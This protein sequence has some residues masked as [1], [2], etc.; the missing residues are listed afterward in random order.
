MF[1]LSIALCLATGSAL[2]EMPRFQK[3]PAS[4][5]GLRF[6][7]ANS[8]TAEKRMIETMPGGIAAFDFDNDGLIDIFFANGAGLKKSANRLFKNEGGLKFRDVTATAGLSGEGYAIGAVAGDF[9]N[10]G[11]TDLFVAGDR[12]NLLY[13]NSGHGKFEDITAKS[14]I[15]SDEWSIAGG[16]FDYDADGL[17]DLFIANYG[18]DTQETRYCGDAAKKLRIYCH[19]KYFAPR[20]NQLYRNLGGGKFEDVTMKSGIGAHKG[21]GMSIA[22]ADYDADGWIDIFVTNDNLANFLFRNLGNG[23]FEE[24]A[25]LA[26]VALLDHGKPIA[27]MGADFRDADNDGRPDITVTALSGETFPFFRN[28][29]GGMF[30]DATFASKIGPLS[31]QRAGWANAWIDFNND[32]WKDLFSANAHVNDLVEQFEPGVTYKQANS[33]FVN[34]NG[35]T[36]VDSQCPALAAAKAAHRGAAFADFDNDGRIDVVVSVLGEPAELWR[37][38]AES[39]NAWLDVKVPSNQVGA[40]ITITAGDKKQWNIYSPAVGYASTCLL[41]TSDAADE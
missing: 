31:T 36:F 18:R 21:R 4:D 39:A 10:D 8:P 41:Y 1:R 2:A 3:I 27:S 30:H 28:D 38:V 29:G 35:K 22:F 15:K 17:L 20:P 37:N 24:T 7:L 16:W 13:R 11:L 9:D 23:K 32:G 6:T 14:G 40:T 34:Q 5:S 25:L 19:P 26:G 33:V 12:H